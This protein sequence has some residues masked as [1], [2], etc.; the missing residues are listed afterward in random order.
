MLR[1]PV[2]D[3]DVIVFMRVPFTRRPYEAD[4]YQAAH[5]G[6]QA[7]EEYLAALRREVASAAD[8]LEG[9][10]VRAVLVGGGAA[11]AADPFALSRLLIEFR[12]QAEHVRGMELS[13]RLEPGA[14]G[15]PLLTTL[16]SCGYTRVVLAAEATAE[17]QLEA[18]GAPHTMA[19]L[20]EAVDC[21]GLFH[22]PNIDT[23]LMYG[24]PGQTET[25]LRNA[26]V[27]AS[28]GAGMSHVTLR[29]FGGKGSEGVAEDERRELFGAA[30]GRLEK[31]GFRLYAACSFAR[32]GFESDYTV[33]DALGVDRIGFGLGARSFVGGT[34]WRNT[35][36]YGRYVAHADEFDQVVED[37]A[38]WDE[39]SLARR[40]LCG[41]LGL[42]Q[43]FAAEEFGERF[44][45]SRGVLDAALG[46][47]EEAGLA[48]V[49]GD[50]EQVGDVGGQAGGGQAGGGQAG[51]AG[52]D[53]GQVRPTV[54]GLRRPDEVSRLVWGR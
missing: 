43:G 30:A 31:E 11:S 20:T 7:R 29:P 40:F 39:E 3:R 35:T 37:V 48:L 50:G 9:R 10:R 52:G 16:G 17:K 18:I 28:A 22:V 5:V 44:P 4:P 6:K 19:E 24:V 12:R 23:E 45:G 32:A 42:A 14:V 26:A 27:T 54:E 47:L 46:R 25:S 1:T 36:D 15:S 33:S 8:L 53:G 49:G 2:E 34:S 38:A 13:V 21:M 41:R 51:G